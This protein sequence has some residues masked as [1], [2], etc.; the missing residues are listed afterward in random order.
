MK[1]V[2][3]YKTLSNILFFGILILAIQK[4]FFR[5]SVPK[6]INK[7]TLYVLITF[8]IAAIIL[9]ILKKKATLKS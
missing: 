6:N 4:F 1:K 3:L 5:N 9:E 8:I 2:K 7:I